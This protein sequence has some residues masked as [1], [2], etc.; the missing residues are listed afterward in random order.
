MELINAR[1]RLVFP[2]SEIWEIHT[3]II[4]YSRVMLLCHI[5]ITSIIPSSRKY[6]RNLSTFV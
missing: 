1:T 4:T 3:Y 5:T 2:L 6:Y